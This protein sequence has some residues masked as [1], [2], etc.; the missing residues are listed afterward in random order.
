MDLLF[1]SEK[2]LQEWKQSGGLYEAM[3]LGGVEG[4]KAVLVEITRHYID[5]CTFHREQIIALDMFRCVFPITIGYV[6]LR[7]G[8]LLY[9][10]PRSGYLY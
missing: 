9:Y 1:G 4:G 8:Q 2:G 10:P 5:I 7:T 3:E 6:S